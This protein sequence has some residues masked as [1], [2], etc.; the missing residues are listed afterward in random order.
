MKKVFLSLVFTAVFLASF[1]QQKFQVS[2][3]NGQVQVTL[4]NQERLTYSISHQ[5]N[6]LFQPST[7]GFSLNRP[8]IDLT[9]FEV[10]GSEEKEVNQSW[11]PIY[12]ERSKIKDHY[13]ELRLRLQTKTQAKVQVNLVFKVY[14]DG[15][16]F[17]YEFPEQEGFKHFI[18]GEELTE[19]KMGADHSA[20]WIPGDYDTNEFLY[21]TTRLSE[22]KSLAA[23]A[24]EIDIAVKSPIGDNFVQTP[25]QLVTDSGYY[26]HIHEA[27]LVNYPVMQL[28]L[29]KA[30][31][32]LKSHLVPDAVGNKAY[33]QTGTST[34][35]RSIIISKTPEGILASDLILNLND[36]AQ[37]EYYSWVTP[38][39]FIGVWWEM[40]VGKGTWEY[41]S[42]KHAANT[43]NVKK[44]IDFAAKYG[45]EG[46]L[47]EGWNEG[48]EDWFGNWKEEVFDFVTP[49]PDYAIKEL[50]EYARSKNV[51][52]IMH[53]ETSGSVTNYER[54]LEDALDFMVANDI[55]TVKTGY[56]GKIIPRG[57]HHDSQW[58]NR[59]YVHVGKKAAE[60]KIMVV[61]HESSR[62]TGLNRTYPNMM[63]SEAAR[64]N[65]FNNAPTFGLTPEH[66]TI[67]AFT[68]LKGG[69]M[70]YTP[71]F[72]DFKLNRF[73]ASRTTQVN[74]TISKQAAL[75]VVFYS[76]IQMLG[77]L[78]ENLEK[79]PDL[80]R[81]IVDIPLDWEESTYLK[82]APGGQ[83]VVARKAK[84]NGVWYVAGISDEQAREVELDF[85]FLEK[86]KTYTVHLI[87]DSKDAHYDLNPTGMESKSS[88]VKPGQKM[89]VRMAQGGG[90]VM[91]ISQE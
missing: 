81:F 85:S 77:D 32:T 67:L 36:P 87:Q 9:E 28:E 22:V 52:L 78:P 68:R 84:E 23:N 26:I 88:S 2:S 24:E 33:L 80:V 25:L 70:D 50:S 61:S 10:L 47:V 27:A 89:K 37:E 42:G 41:A 34:P 63:A 64:G 82:S 16:G 44:Y 19:F 43:A 31:Y 29:D 59:H 72:F 73:D 90:F 1:G 62:P 7:L 56:V 13:R 48:W 4:S 75:F 18:V 39:K 46:V 40:H 38:Q 14:D 35:W 6:V 17:R 65:E 76:P 45:I 55:N 83:V 21:K 57:E 3:P 74:T 66:E 91:K 69:P 49:Y 53:H 60:K 86:G 5:E 30:D 11:T 54:R 12:G 71:G 15:V 51:R 58:M 20:F 79:Y 8:E